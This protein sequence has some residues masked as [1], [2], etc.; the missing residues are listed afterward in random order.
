M[1]GYFKNWQLKLNTHSPTSAIKTP[2]R[3]LSKRTSTP[4]PEKNIA[5]LDKN[6]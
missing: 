4:L 2:C 6:R 5:Y 3:M 1:S